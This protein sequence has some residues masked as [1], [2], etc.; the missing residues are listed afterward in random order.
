MFANASAHYLLTI[1]AY[2]H[3]FRDMSNALTHI[4]KTIFGLTQ[5][6]FAAALGRNQS[7]ISRWERSELAPDLQDMKDIQRLA[8]ERGIE[9]P[10][11]LFFT[12]PPAD[13]A[14]ENVSESAA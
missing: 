1:N 2:A 3:T 6:Q 10:E 4:R 14:P 12:D 5:G 8:I 13:F 11:S 7:T 9:C